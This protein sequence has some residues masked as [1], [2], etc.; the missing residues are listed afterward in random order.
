M[1]IT[2]GI[3]IALPSLSAK[4]I[5]AIRKATGLSI[6]DIKQRAQNGDYLMEKDLSDDKGLFSIIKLA[7]EL[8]ALGLDVEL[9]QGGYSRSL[10]FMK[11]VLESHR[12]TAREVGPKD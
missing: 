4:A 10:E 5:A 2:N 7:E 11:N 3:R 9:C 1:A 8:S 12:Q 6:S